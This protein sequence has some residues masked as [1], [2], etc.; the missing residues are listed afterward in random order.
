MV[1]YKEE[2]VKQPPSL[3]ILE[4]DMAAIAKEL[5]PNTEEHMP[6]S[7]RTSFESRYLSGT[8]I[9]ILWIFGLLVWCALF[10]W[11]PS[12]GKSK[13]P[14]RKKATNFKEV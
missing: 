13:T 4:G 6:D 1:F 2:E 11:V 10:M 14:H 7:L 8:L 3:E 5:I 9:F 12:S